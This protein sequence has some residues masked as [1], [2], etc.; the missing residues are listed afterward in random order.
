MAA[1]ITSYAFCSVFPGSLMSYLESGCVCVCH[2]NLPA[3]IL[4]PLL[5]IYQKIVKS[6]QCRSF[7]KM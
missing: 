4:I 1:A 7:F 6:L 2:E 3:E 5:Q